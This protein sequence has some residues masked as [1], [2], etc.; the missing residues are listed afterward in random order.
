MDQHE[1]SIKKLKVF[2]PSR[3]GRSHQGGVTTWHRGGRHK[4]FYRIIDW[5]RSVRDVE[6]VVR[7]IEYDPNRNVNIALIA[8]PGGTLAY[9]LHPIGLEV[10]Q[11]VIAGDVTPIKPGNA[12]PLKNIPIGVQ[13]HNIE[14][15]P[16]KGG[17]IVRSAGTS[18]VIIG[19]DDWYAHVKLPSGEV[20]KV[21]LSCIGT[22]GQLDNENKK[23]EEIGSAGRARHMGHRP[24]VRGVAQNPHSHPHGG[25]EGRSSEGMHPKTPWGKPARGVKT[26]KPK[27]YSDSLI[28]SRRK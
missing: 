19:K 16:G 4:R 21:L 6:G 11:T 28:V 10:D 18:S 17:Q 3:G 1:T 26:R 5:A 9:I 25:G 7:S 13:I 27:R 23:H 2:L 8:Y 14:L 24:H 20:R 15:T 12:M 22:I